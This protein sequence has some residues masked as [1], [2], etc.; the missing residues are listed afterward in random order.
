MIYLFSMTLIST[1]FQ[2]HVKILFKKLWCW[3]W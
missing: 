2:N 3:N 1:K